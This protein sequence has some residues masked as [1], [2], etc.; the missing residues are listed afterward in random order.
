MVADVNG[1]DVERVG[2]VALSFVV[3]VARSYDDMRY[4]TFTT[5]FCMATECFS[6][7]YMTVMG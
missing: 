3:L 4:A 7:F 6:V 2:C 1:I 5:G